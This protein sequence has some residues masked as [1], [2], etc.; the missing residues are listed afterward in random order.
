MQRK[1][2]VLDIDQPEEQ[3]ASPYSTYGLRL[4]EIEQQFFANDEFDP[5]S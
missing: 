5:N 1:Y 3:G 4:D 2:K